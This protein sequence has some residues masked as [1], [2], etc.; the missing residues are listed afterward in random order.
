MD[1]PPGFVAGADLDPAET[2]VGPFLR[3]DTAGGVTTGL[4]V[5]PQHCNEHGTLHGGV[6]MA[7]ADYTA[8]SAARFGMGSEGTM[9]V[10]FDARFVDAGRLGDWVEGHATVVRRTGSMVFVEGRL[11]CDGRPLLSFASV[12]KRLRDR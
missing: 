5:G 1:V 11:L 4:L 6:Q 10:S 7:L 12:V 9:T 3:R 8:G 2:H